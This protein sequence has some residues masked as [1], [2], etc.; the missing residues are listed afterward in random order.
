VPQHHSTALW[1]SR[2][3]TTSAGHPCTWRWRADDHCW[4]VRG[5]VPQPH[6]PRPPPACRE[7]V[8]A[9]VTKLIRLHQLLV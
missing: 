6:H 9:K 1:R 4:V 5:P 7:S 8:L 2:R 3:A